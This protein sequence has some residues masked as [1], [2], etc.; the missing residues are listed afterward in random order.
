MT[1][2]MLTLNHQRRE[3]ANGHRMDA[4]LKLL[5]E[6]SISENNF[7]ERAIM[8]RWNRRFSSLRGKADTCPSN[9]VM[10]QFP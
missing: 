6:T 8:S 3:E 2:A 5:S 10:S 7:W 4:F 1:F 9:S